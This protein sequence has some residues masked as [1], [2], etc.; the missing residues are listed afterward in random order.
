MSGTDRDS[1]EQ[2]T[3]TSTSWEGYGKAPKPVLCH[4]ARIHPMGCLVPFGNGQSAV[5]LASQSASLPIRISATKNRWRMRQWGWVGC[6]SHF[7]HFPTRS[8]TVT[9]KRKH[10]AECVVHWC[11][12]LP[13]FFFLHSPH[14]S[15][16]NAFD[17]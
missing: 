10:L 15:S 17:S 12:L 6:G 9:V 7:S 2:M 8:P 13:H 1:P 3:V 16:N 14:F 5:H 11:M 4:T